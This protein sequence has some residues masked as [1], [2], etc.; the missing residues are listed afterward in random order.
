MDYPF[1]SDFLQEWVGARMIL[2]GHAHELY[3]AEVFRAWQHDRSVVGFEWNPDRHYPPV[4]PPWH[5]A[6]FVPF[7]LMPYRWATI[8]W[9]ALLWGAVFINGYLIRSII[10]Q[11]ETETQSSTCVRWKQSALW[12]LPVLLFPT[13][14]MAVMFGQKSL[15]WS[16]ILSLVVYCLKRHRHV[17]SGAMFALMMFKPTLFYLIPLCMARYRNGSFLLGCGAVVAVISGVS[18]A[19]LPWGL[20]QGYLHAMLHSVDYGTQGGYRIDW[21]CNVWSI[22]LGAPMAWRGWVKLLVCLPCACFVLV[23]LL[24]PQGMEIQPR[25]VFQWLV[26]TLLLAPHAYHYDLCILLLPICWMAIYEPR[27][28]VVTFSI[29]AFGVALSTRIYPLVP[30]PLLPFALLGCFWIWRLPNAVAAA[31]SEGIKAAYGFAGTGDIRF[32]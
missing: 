9:V 10:F 14:P 27:L 8:L 22:A 11:G 32:R 17:W 31:N 20:W 4:Y 26:A 7:A 23:S 5:Y 24:K 18:L 3:D 6:L 13:V 25:V 21:S 29:L 12:W 16:A 30:V 2:T 1:G 15:I 19:I 28:S